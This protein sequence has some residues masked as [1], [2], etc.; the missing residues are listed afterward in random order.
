MAQGNYPHGSPEGLERAINAE[1]DAMIS[2]DVDRGREPTMRKPS[3]PNE[4]A[5][6]LRGEPDSPERWQQAA[7]LVGDPTL[8]QRAYYD[9]VAG[10]LQNAVHAI[11]RAEARGE[12]D[13]QT[14]NAFAAA[15][16]HLAATGDPG[17]YA[18]FEDAIAGTEAEEYLEQAVQ[19]AQYQQANADQD[20]YVAM[21]QDRLDQRQQLLAR[22][23]EIAARRQGQRAVEAVDQVVRAA[24]DEFYSPALSDD[25]ARAITRSTAEHA[26]ANEAASRNLA[27]DVAIT[28]EMIRQGG[29][30]SSMNDAERERWEADMR[31]TVIEN[32][33]NR[34]GDPDAATDRVIR[35]IIED[36]KRAETGKNAF[37]RAIEAEMDEHDSHARQNLPHMQQFSEERARDFEATH[38]ELG[39]LTSSTDSL[40][41]ETER[42]G[43]RR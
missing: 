11:Q 4:P 23:Y 5:F 28:E 15:T 19:L 36:D 42:R 41:R 7:E 38:D 27:A 43:D 35:S 32:Y 20:A 16:R 2:H 24:Q 30:G 29:P 17:L 1:L 31:R 39:R 6:K 40:G 37:V 14:V 25:Q 3:K 18:S 12:Y 33:Q 26:R 9:R 10:E 8:V 34:L 22:E 13:Y 21:E